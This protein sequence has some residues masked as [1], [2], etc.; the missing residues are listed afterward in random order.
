MA[1]R[2]TVKGLLN[3][4][5]DF[6]TR[7]ILL[8]LFRGFGLSKLYVFT[9]TIFDSMHGDQRSRWLQEGFSSSPGYSCPT[10]GIG[11]LVT[12]KGWNLSKMNASSHYQPEGYLLQFPEESEE[13]FAGL[14]SCSNGHCSESVAISGIVKFIPFPGSLYN[15][16][17][18]NYIPKFFLPALRIIAVGHTCPSTVKEQIN[19][20]FT[21]FFNDL[22]A[23]GNAIRRAVECLVAF[24]EEKNGIVVDPKKVSLQTRI[25]GFTEGEE[26]KPFLEAVKWIGNYGSH[27]GTELGK[28]EIL[29]AYEFLEHC[30]YELFEKEEKMFQLKTRAEQINNNKGPS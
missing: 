9:I 29:D 12:K 23:C 18:R 16:V 14:L 13:H 17:R 22:G 15:D 27:T 30:L 8:P 6:P 7:T 26:I 19:K 10:C 2:Q 24:F 28:N 1:F 21:H 20:S 25:N 3:V 5:E 4:F 11:M